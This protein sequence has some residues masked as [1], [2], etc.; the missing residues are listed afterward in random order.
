MKITHSVLLAISAVLFSAPLFAQSDNA[1]DNADPNAAFLRCGTKHPSP[2]EARLIEE[3]FQRLRGQIA[4]SSNAKGKPGGGGEEPPPKPPTVDPVEIAVVFHIIRDGSAGQVSTGTIDA[5][6]T[7]LND[8]FSSA[9]APYS[10]KLAEVTDTNDSNWYQNCGSSSV[11]AAMKTKLRRGGPET[12]NVYSC[13]PDGGLLGWATF[14]SWYAS[15]P[16]DDGV[17]ILDDS[18]PGGSATNY[19]QGDTLTHEVG[20]WLGLYHTF[21]GG[22]NGSG[23]Y[24]ADTPA[25]RS[26][27]YGCPIGSDSCRRDTGLDPI[28]NFMDYTYDSCMYEFSQGQVARA[29]EQS[30]VLRGLGTP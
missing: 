17:V 16:K 30:S 19:N 18:L 5:Q 26:P 8:A 12:L 4:K 22:C 11:E 24:V 7:V 10:F 27:A 1:Y 23:D 20:H 3:Q 29:Y 6:M 14:P 25:E 2:E 15:N 13:H 28:H 9:E 21:Q